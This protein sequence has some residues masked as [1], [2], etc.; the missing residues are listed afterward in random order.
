MMKRHKGFKLF[1]VLTI[2]TIVLFVL[3]P[4]PKDPKLN[5]DIPQVTKNLLELENSIKQSEKS[6]KFLEP[7][8]R[9]RIIWADSSHKK[10]TKYSVVYLHGFGGTWMDG[11]P[12][13]TQFAKRYGFNLFLSRLQYHG[14]ENDN[15]LLGLSP[16]NYL[17]SA[18]YA[19]AVGKALGD[20]VIIMATSTGGTLALTLAKDHPEISALILFSPNIEL[21]NK[22]SFILTK[23]WGLQIARLI[24][25]GKFKI[26]NDP[27]SLQ[28]YWLRKYRIESLVSL[29]SLIENTMNKK[30]FSMVRQPVF[31]GYY[32]KNEN[33]Q[34]TTVSVKRELEMFSE[35]GTRAEMK[36][37]VNFPK[38][39][40]HPIASCLMSKDVNNVEKETF[41]FS[42]NVLKYKPINS[43]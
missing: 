25:G 15:P 35:L 1:L 38:S 34:D 11:Y 5:T 40:V 20:S 22:Y 17:A 29:E 12:V 32:Y 2:F 19:I 41:N 26:N 43:K 23:P 31:L 21:Y 6:I 8:N 27:V 30:T 3:G 39:G 7:E 24:Q 4:K 37:K 28:K 14:I 10:K 18:A 33:E 42:D 16:D 9:A 13:N 36:M